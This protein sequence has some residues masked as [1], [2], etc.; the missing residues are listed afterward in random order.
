LRA[1]LLAA[2]AAA[3]GG[4]GAC[5]VA[6]A[7]QQRP[8]W[9]AHWANPDQAEQ[10][11]ARQL[12]GFATNFVATTAVDIGAGSAAPAASLFPP[13]TGAPPPLTASQLGVGLLSVGRALAKLPGAAVFALTL[14]APP[15]AEPLSVAA[16]L[17]EL[18]ARAPPV[19]R[20]A[21]RGATRDGAVALDAALAHPLAVF[22]AL[23]APGGG[24]EVA[25][26]REGSVFLLRGAG[27]IKLSSLLSMNGEGGAGAGAPE[28]ALEDF[29]ALSCA[30]APAASLDAYQ[31]VLRW[32]PTR[33]QTPMPQERIPSA[34]WDEF[35]INGTVP[36]GWEYY[37]EAVEPGGE[38]HGVTY[39]RA[40]IE[41]FAA[42]AR[43]R[44]ENY[45]GV[46]DTYLYALLTRHA[47][48]V[49]GKRVVVMGSLEPW[50]EMVA[51]EFGSAGVAT[52]EYSPRAAED[53][54]FSFFTP[55]EMDA[56]IAAGTWERFDVALSI[57]S[58]EHDGL[59]RYGDPLG[60]E[61]D[62]ATLRTVARSVLKPGGHLVLS[63]PV[64]GDCLVFNAHRV[65]GRKRLALIER[66]WTRVDA[67][68]PHGANL[69]P[70][71]DAAPCSWVQPILLLQNAK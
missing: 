62:L 7:P 58:F 37:N 21:V 40:K 45:Y 15:G 38:R 24:A 42:K 60:G 55:S 68:G 66:G 19:V 14:P 33:R 31:G 32:Y 27:S 57:S 2:A 16:A 51:L 64:G 36:V 23:A 70:L 41:A 49:R 18:D 52:V 48:L 17:A 34:L 63:F 53:P 59:G 43:N 29:V 22:A 71:L 11:F 5:G 61:A 3:R 1:R 6:R 69:E 47:H 46:T 10:R 13:P 67:E 54:R 56:R 8:E 30:W 28:L 50:Y 4:N 44:E 65:Y 25:A 35:T 26:A 39:T 20:D 9:D 12:A